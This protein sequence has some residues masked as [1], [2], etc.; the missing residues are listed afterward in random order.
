MIREV[1]SSSAAIVDVLRS[2]E[3]PGG[4]GLGHL[5]AYYRR[6]SGRRGWAEES[7]ADTIEL[8]RG[9]LDEFE[10]AGD[11]ERRLEYADIQLCVTHLANQAGIDADTAVAAK[12]SINARCFG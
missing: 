2:G 9:E 5:Q 4:H 12:E 6:A 7:S 8:L 1:P 3:S 10:A 11:V